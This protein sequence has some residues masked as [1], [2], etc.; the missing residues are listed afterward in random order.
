MNINSNKCQTIHPLPFIILAG[1]ILGLVYSWV[2]NSQQNIKHSP[3]A[4]EISFYERNPPISE[5]AKVIRS[6]VPSFEGQPYFVASVGK[7]IPY[8]KLPTIEGNLVSLSD[9][10]GKAVFINLWASWCP[11]CKLEMPDIE[12]A[13]EKYQA[14][15]LVVLGINV[16]TQDNLDDVKAFIEEYN[17]TF[18]ILLDESGEVSEELFHLRGLPTSFFIDSEGILQRIHI[19]AIPKMNLETFIIEILPK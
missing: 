18:P 15:N 13:Y 10:K 6:T 4:T 17:L 11:P 8:F 7:S 12:A 14:Q 5:T 9:F 16:T 1:L 3:T 2:R 19:G